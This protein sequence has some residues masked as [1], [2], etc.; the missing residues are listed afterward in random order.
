M[1]SGGGG[2]AGVIITQPLRLH[3]TDDGVMIRP[4]YSPFAT[5][6]NVADVDF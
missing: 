4:H 2:Y 3:P 6:G 5:H 1:E